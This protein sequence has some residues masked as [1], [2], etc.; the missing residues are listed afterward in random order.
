MCV[1]RQ[2]QLDKRLFLIDFQQ[3]FGDGVIHTVMDIKGSRVPVSDAASSDVRFV[4]EDQRR[5]QRVDRHAGSFVVIADGR[6]DGC[7][8]LGR[9]AQPRQ[10]LEGHHRAALRV[11]DAVDQ[12]ADIVQIARNLGK[13]HR[14]RVIAKRL[15]NVTRRFRHVG[16]VGKAVFRITERNQRLV[17]LADVGTDRLIG[18]NFM[19][20]HSILLFPAAILQIGTALPLWTRRKHRR[21]PLPM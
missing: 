14:V 10:N 5:R 21:M 12:I 6:D 3:G 13:L 16:H 9:A 1:Y 19:K 18:R 17:G 7:H 2:F 11:V 8:I 4:R 15:K 20:C